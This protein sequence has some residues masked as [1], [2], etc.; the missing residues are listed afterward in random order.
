M[1]RPLVRF[2]GNKFFKTLLIVMVLSNL[3]ACRII[4]NTIMPLDKNFNDRQTF[5]LEDSSFSSQGPNFQYFD[6]RFEQEIGEFHIAN[7]DVEGKRINSRRDYDFGIAPIG[8]LF[9]D[10]SF[11]REEWKNTFSERY[12]FSFDVM[13]NQKRLNRAQCSAQ[14]TGSATESEE[15]F[16]SKTE[17]EGET[18]EFFEIECILGFEGKTATLQIAEESYKS[19]QVFILSEHNLSM[20]PSYQKEYQYSS[21]ES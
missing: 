6:E 10:E 9:L 12:R 18:K 3:S 20:T 8:F 17:S 13:H 14:V 2:A 19:V 15:I 5:T 11:L 4:E 1:T 16:S 7:V 21:G